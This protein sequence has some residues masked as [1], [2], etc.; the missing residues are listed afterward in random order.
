MRGSL[1]VKAHGFGQKGLT[2]CD[3]CYAALAQELGGTWITFDS[4]AHQSIRRE[5]LSWDLDAGPPPGW[6]G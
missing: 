5:K 6:P 1:A 3:A 2:G 4:K